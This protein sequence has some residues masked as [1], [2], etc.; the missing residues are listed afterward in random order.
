MR[1]SYERRHHLLTGTLREHFAGFPEPIESSGENPRCQHIDATIYAE[2]DAQI[3]VGLDAR[4]DGPSSAACP[5][6]GHPG[7]GVPCRG[8]QPGPIQ[9]RRPTLLR[10]SRITWPVIAA[11]QHAVSCKKQNRRPKIREREVNRSH[12]TIHL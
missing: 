10:R 1:G 5:G 11:Q 3:R 7:R 6:W 2:L 8:R 9:Q 4:P 12:R